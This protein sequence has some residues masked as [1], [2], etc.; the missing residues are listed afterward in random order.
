MHPGRRLR[1]QHLKELGAAGDW[2]DLYRQTM[3]WEFGHEARM[4]WQLAFLRPFCTPGMAKTLVDAGH[5]VH[6]P[7]KRAYDTGLIIYEIVYHGLEHPRARQ[8][9]SIMNQA[10]HGRNLKEIDMTYVLS[11][12]IVAPYRYIK[13]AGWRPLLDVEKQAAVRFYD[14]LGEL[15]N[16]ENR[17][18][19]F[20]EAEAFLDAYEAKNVIP[21]PDAAIL[22]SKLM[23]VFRGRLP[24][25]LRSRAVP[26]FGVLLNDRRIDAALGYTPPSR[27]LQ[28]A[29]DVVA[30]LYAAVHAWLPPM[31]K[32]LFTPGN[33][34]G[35]AYPTGYKPEDLGPHAES[36]GE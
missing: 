10:H 31:T 6:S 1:T 23:E 5:L 15:M 18:A 13:W 24:K 21:S 22:G 25:P 8:M 12:F 35:H 16:I 11:A 33:K 9:V 34:A 36:A 7:L 3:L 14:R 20:E 19:S 4:G 32:P 29:A 27:P 17:P 26:L 30:K 2:E 28:V